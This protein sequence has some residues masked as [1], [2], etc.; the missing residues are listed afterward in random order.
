MSK[1]IAIIP[2]RGGSK[3]ISGKNKSLLGGKPLISH[4]I[5][6]AINCELLTEIIVT[7]DDKKILIW[8][9]GTPVVTKHISEPHLHSVPHMS[10]HPNGNGFDYFFF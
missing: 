2:A 8:D 5:E 4:T 6:P 3:G 10:L 1:L 7:S 9:Y